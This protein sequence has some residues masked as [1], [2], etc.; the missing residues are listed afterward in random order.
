MPTR[1]SLYVLLSSLALVAA[2]CESTATVDS[3]DLGSAAHPDL[4]AYVPTGTGPAAR[5]KCDSSG[6]NAFDTYGTAA[7]VAVNE[8]IVANVFAEVG[9]HA[10]A[11][12]GDSFTKLGSG[13]P[14]AATND[15]A[16]FKGKLAAFLVYVYGGPDHIT[17][18]DGKSYAGVQD[19]V[20]AHS[21]FGIT[22][23]QYDYFVA[24]IV[25][26]ALTKSGVPHGSGGAA[27]PDDVGSCFAP[28]LL[29]PAFKATIVAD[30]TGT[31][32]AA[33]VKCESSGKNAFATYGAAAFIAV[34]EAIVANVFSEVGAHGSMNVGDSFGKIGSGN[35][36]STKDDAATFKGKL[37]AF[38]VYAYGGPSAIT[39]T[40]NKMYFGLQDM[41]AAHT[42][43]GVTSAQYD[44]FITNIV[45][46]AL[47]SSGV[48]HGAGGA[49]DPNDVTTCFAP[50]VTGAAFKASI[51]GH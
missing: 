40:D 41:V 17:Y 16:T 38:L 8:A 6:K 15:A 25:V 11:N 14:P 35:P 42:G 51:V 30:G 28:P 19:M 47:V 13:N 20:A 21:G 43:L 44:Y 24:N 37:A 39:Y 48:K 32:P 1:T 10:S 7:F 31:G 5:L 22:A 27:S 33:G 46:P 26:P 4:A 45:V 36:A 12:V 3:A 49:N 18:T 34:N 50:V 23:A 9:A 2:G 29:D